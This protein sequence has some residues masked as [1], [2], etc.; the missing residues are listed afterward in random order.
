[1]PLVATRSNASARGYG[2]SATIPESLDGMVLMKPT[3][4]VSTGTGNSSSIGTNGSVTFSSCATLTLD[5]VF[6]ADYD[7]YV[8]VSR[9]NTASGTYELYARLR[10]SGSDASGTDYTRQQIFANGTSVTGARQTSQTSL[11][12]G[13]SSDEQRSAESV[14]FYGPYLS[15]PTATRTVSVVGKDSGRIIDLACTHSLSTSYTGITI[16]TEASTISGLIAVYGL[17]N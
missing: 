5:G 17:E 3:S 11:R 6:T 15:Q 12:V 14:Y 13:S 8:I 2:W 7:N 4:I 1:M 16:I 10:A 9:H